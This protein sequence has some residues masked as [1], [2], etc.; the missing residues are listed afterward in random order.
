[1]SRTGPRKILFCNHKWES[2]HLTHLQRL[3]SLRLLLLRSQKRKLSF[4][5]R[6][7]LARRATTPS[8]YDSFSLS[9]RGI[10]PRPQLRV[11]TQSIQS[12][13]RR[14]ATKSSG[15]RHTCANSSKTRPRMVPSVW[16]CAWDEAEH[17]LRVQV[18]WQALRALSVTLGSFPSRR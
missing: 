4:L 9:P 13:K 11:T 7:D 16:P 1:M 3:N 10:P 14:C 18:R 8:L 5:T 15:A 12:R 2:V 6:P 17:R